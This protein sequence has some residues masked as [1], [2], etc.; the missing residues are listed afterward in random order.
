[1][2]PP[3][4]DLRVLE[5]SD[6]TAGFYCG[7]LFR[8]AGAL[9]TLVEPAAATYR[10]GHGLRT[11][12]FHFLNGGKRSVVVGKEE[13]LVLAGQSDVVIVTGTP[14]EARAGGIDVA[15]LSGPTNRTIV[16]TISTFGW[17]GPWAERP[18]T[19]SVPLGLPW[20]SSQQRP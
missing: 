2:D 13:V 11:P 9:V 10:D 14:D 17:T 7:K 18:A 16:V 12:L 5:I 6:R 20:W 19:V 15:R 3:L 4:G 1:M 8:D